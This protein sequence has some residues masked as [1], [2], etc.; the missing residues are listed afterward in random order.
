MD[1]TTPEP[2]N[3]D[4]L[5][6]VRRF[7]AAWD[8]H[9]LD[10]TLA[11]VTDDCVFESARVGANGERVVGRDALRAVWAPGFREARGRFEIEELFG[12]GDRAVQR[13]RFI[14][15]DRVV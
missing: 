11:L 2:P 10:A 6:T 4:V 5:D 8:A 1:T 12:A 15:G 14:D 13:W 3:A 7:Q 9:D